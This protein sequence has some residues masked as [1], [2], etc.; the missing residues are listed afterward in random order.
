MQRRRQVDRTRDSMEANGMLMMSLEQLLVITTYSSNE[1][2]I[3]PTFPFNRS[4]LVWATTFFSD[5]E[6]CVRGADGGAIRT[7]FV[8]RIPT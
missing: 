8:E 6:G 5:S 1:P 4:Y 3:F 2:L 7:S